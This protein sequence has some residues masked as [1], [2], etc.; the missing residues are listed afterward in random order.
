MGDRSTINGALEWIPD[1]VLILGGE[2][3]ILLVNAAAERLF[4]YS[5]AEL[6]GGPIEVCLPPMLCGRCLELLDYTG[7]VEPRPIEALELEAQFPF[8]TWRKA[9][10]F[11]AGQWVKLARVR[12]RPRPPWRKDSRSRRAGGCGN[13]PAGGVTRR[14]RGRGPGGLR[15]EVGR[16]QPW[17]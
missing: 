1:A 4:G 8:R 10:T 12:L 13:R 16:R 6:I 5:R 15:V 9:S 2:G 11:S 14:R 17:G 7:K 3:Q